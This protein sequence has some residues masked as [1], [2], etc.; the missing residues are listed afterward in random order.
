MRHPTSRSK[1]PHPPTSNRTEPQQPTHTAAVSTLGASPAGPGALSGESSAFDDE[2]DY[3]S[4]LH[5][6]AIAK[7]A[8]AAN[9]SIARPEGGGGVQCGA[10]VAHY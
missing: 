2:D 5:Q 4:P 7:Y 3:S 10:T 8:Q 9:V 1:T 6:Q